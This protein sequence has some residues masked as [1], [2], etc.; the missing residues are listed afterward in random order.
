VATVERRSGDR[1]WA[2]SK[3]EAKRASKIEKNQAPPKRAAVNSSSD[4]SE[5]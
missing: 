4:W 2:K 5:F 1:P 3:V